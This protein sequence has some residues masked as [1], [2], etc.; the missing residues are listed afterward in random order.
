MANIGVSCSMIELNSSKSS[1]TADTAF[2]KDLPCR[3]ALL[4]PY[5]H[6]Q[7]FKQGT[8]IIMP[9][10]LTTQPLPS[11]Q[12]SPV[13]HLTKFNPNRESGRISE[14]DLV[15]A[16]TTLGGNSARRM[17]PTSALDKRTYRTYTDVQNKG[18]QGTH[19]FPQSK[20]EP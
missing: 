20:I 10:D 18:L 12:T 14:T 9:S 2:R 19:G 5:T 13:S 1:I 6:D 11:L 17:I 7:P 4:Y 8:K 16:T 15:V 3:D